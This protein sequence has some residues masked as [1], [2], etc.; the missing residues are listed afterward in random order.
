[1]D[2]RW[3]TREQ[4]AAWVRLV[5][6]VELLPGGLDAQLRRDAGLTPFDYLLPALPPE[7]PGAVPRRTALAGQ[8]N[9]NLPRLS[10]VVR[11]LEDRGL[12]ERSPAPEDRRASDVRL[13]AEGRQA[14][15]A[16]APGHV[17]TVRERVIDA[18]TDE[19]V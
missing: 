8:T 16:A 17:T 12:V 11:R 18:L 13:T 3:L 6:L 5:A 9:A 2:P 19:Q 14:V 10:N 7:G 4:L 15:Q 1:M